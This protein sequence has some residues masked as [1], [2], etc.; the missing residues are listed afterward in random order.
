MH[1]WQKIFV[2]WDKQE[3]TWNA[4]FILSWNTGNIKIQTNEQIN[5]T[6]WQKKT[7]TLTLNPAFPWF[8]LIILW[9]ALWN[10]IN[11]L[12]K[13]DVTINYLLI[14][15]VLKICLGE[16]LPT[17]SS[18]CTTLTFICVL[19]RSLYSHFCVSTSF[20]KPTIWKLIH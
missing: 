2:C 14:S 9:R 18:L 5:C 20:E 13:I 15:N 7:K 3:K 6:M 4:S 11:F 10:W 1:G 16:F 17:T 8:L 12:S 19:A